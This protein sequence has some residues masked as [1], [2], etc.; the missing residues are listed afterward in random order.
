[1]PGGRPR[2]PE[3]KKLRRQIVYFDP[4]TLTC[5]EELAAG[6][7]LPKSE[8]IRQGVRLLYDLS[9]AQGRG[10][11]VQIRTRS[12]RID[13]VRLDRDP[14]VDSGPLRPRKDPR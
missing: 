2:V 10:G 3:G 9:G 7:D 1:M 4:E 12:G 5:L 13:P 14:I 11:Q 8:I 6:A